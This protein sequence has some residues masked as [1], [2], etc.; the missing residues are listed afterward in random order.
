MMDYGPTGP[1]TSPEL[2]DAYAICAPQSSDEV[3]DF[4]PETA[5]S[6]VTPQNLAL[7]DCRITP[8]RMEPAEASAS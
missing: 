6:S 4:V 5:L 8:T 1:G 2:R 3:E 7:S